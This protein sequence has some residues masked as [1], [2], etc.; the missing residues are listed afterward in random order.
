M[1]ES[2]Y[3]AVQLN[4]VLVVCARCQ[5]LVLRSLGILD[6]SGVEAFKQGDQRFPF[7]RH[8]LKARDL[9]LDI[10]Q[11]PLRGFEALPESSHFL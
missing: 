8:N 3:I 9:L 7:F 11:D 4:Q 10:F 6:P 1:A 2:R 5:R